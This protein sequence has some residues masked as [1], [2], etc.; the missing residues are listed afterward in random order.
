MSRRAARDRRH[1]R[2]LEAVRIYGAAQGVADVAAQEETATFLNWVEV[3]AHARLFRGEGSTDAERAARAQWIE[4]RDRRVKSDAR[5][6]AYSAEL[7]QVLRE[8]DAI[9]PSA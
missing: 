2:L 9:G 4:A 1:R 5:L 3:A 6:R 7:D 8:L